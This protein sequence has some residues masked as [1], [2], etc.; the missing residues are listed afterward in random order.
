MEKMLFLRSLKQ[1]LFKLPQASSVDSL[2]PN[3]KRDEIVRTHETVKTPYERGRVLKDSFNN[4]LSNARNGQR[5][6]LRSLPFFFRS[7]D[8]IKDNKREAE[9]LPYNRFLL[10]D[11]RGGVSPTA[12]LIIPLQA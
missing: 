9:R 1:S 12:I 2:N 10:Y 6:F 7:T 4:T 3:K 11:R 5:M 8:L